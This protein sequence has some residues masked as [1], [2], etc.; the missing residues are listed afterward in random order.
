MKELSVDVVVR[1][2]EY[3][4]VIEAGL[5]NNLASELKRN[6][7]GKPYAIITDTIVNPLY[8]EPLCRSLREAGIP[9]QGYAFA[10]GEASKT[11]QTKEW[12]ENS[13]LDDGFGRD[14]AILAVGGGVV[15]D[16]AGF[17][18]ATYMRGV[19]F[20]QVPTTTLAPVD[21]SSGGKTAVDVPQGKNLIGAFH[22]PA[23]VYMDPQTLMSLDERNYFGG[24]VE[25]VKHGFI[26]DEEFLAFYRQHQQT[27][28]AR[29]GTEYADMME[30]LMLRNCRIKNEVVRLDEQE[31]NLRKI[32]NYGH[33]LGHGV[34]ILSD[35]LLSHGESVAVGIGFAAYLAWRLG[36]CTRETME[37][38]MDV[39]EGLG[40]PCR[41]PDSI[42]AEQLIRVMSMDKKA[43]DGK[44]EFV[45]LES[46]GK[47]KRAADG[48]CAQ[49]IAPDVVRAMIDEY[50]NIG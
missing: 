37:I 26:A 27:I 12:L 31:T 6:P 15:G 29:S 18:A 1:P 30:E 21:S 14:S 44:A 8:A 25:L 40:M 36:F 17:V 39:L 5:L 48:D 16:V 38:Q 33:T 23:V 47:V 32:L 7:L 10:H 4:I 46:V 9:A 43:K 28:V 13:L 49:K 22:H 2:K 50:K 42:T 19:P 20:A 11:R 45:L 35:F 24:L 41:I 3:R 34:E